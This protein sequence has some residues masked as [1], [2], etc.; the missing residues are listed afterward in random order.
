MPHTSGLFVAPKQSSRNGDDKTS[1]KLAPKAALIWTGKPNVF[2]G[3]QGQG[4]FK[5][6]IPDAIFAGPVGRGELLVTAGY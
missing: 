5:L 1:P 3:L 2:F 6:G 4:P